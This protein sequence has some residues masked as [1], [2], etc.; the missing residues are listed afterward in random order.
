[1]MR[2]RRSER[3]AVRREPSLDE[4]LGD[5]ATRLLM[6][7]DGVDEAMLRDLLAH[8]GARVA[9]AEQPAA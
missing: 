5:P 7:S 4:L 1:M 9:A 8:L 3:A 6:R 2:P